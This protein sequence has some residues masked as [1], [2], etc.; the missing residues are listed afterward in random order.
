MQTNAAVLC[1]AAYAMMAD[2]DGDSRGPG[3]T[4]VD[5]GALESEEQER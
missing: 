4:E 2:D 5:V 1:V 3:R